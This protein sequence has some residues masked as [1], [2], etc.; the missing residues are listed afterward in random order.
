MGYKEIALIELI[1]IE[2]DNEGHKVL[3]NIDLQL[4]KGKIHAIVGDHDSGKSYICELLSG[5][6][7]P[8]RGAMFIDNEEVSNFTIKKAQ[9]WGIQ[10]IYQDMP[11]I[12]NFSI[13]ENLFTPNFLRKRGYYKKSYIYS[14]SK[15]I[16]NKYHL[17]IDP[18]RL[19]KDLHLTDKIVIN[20][21]RALIRSP[22]LLIL[23]ESLEKL[24]GKDIKRV[25]L[26]L[27]IAVKEG[28]SVLC[29]SH[30]IDDIYNFTDSVSILRRGQIFL[31]DSITNIDRLN[32]IKLCYSQINSDGELSNTSREFYQLIKY[33]EAILQKLPTNLIVTDA[34]NR[35]K[36]INESGKKYFSVENVVLR[37]RGIEELL[38]VDNE[39]FISELFVAFSR[40][41]ETSQYSI[42]FLLSGEIRVVNFKTFPI[43][44]GAFLLGNIII[45]EDISE[46][47]KL[48]EQITLSEKLASVGLL[49]AGVAHEI[50]NPLEIIY[51]HLNYLNMGTLNSEYK[52]VITEIEEELK[53]IKSIV[54]NLISFS[55]NNNASTEEY[56]L[57]DLVRSLINLIVFNG[58]HNKISI[59]F[60]SKSEEILVK[61]SK[62]EMKQ[63]LLNLFKNSF[64]AMPNGGEIIISTD[65]IIK[66][67]IN[68]SM[69]TM[70]DNGHGFEEKDLGDLFLP[71]FSTKKGRENNMGLGLSVIY[72]I[73]KKYRGEIS[74]ENRRG[75]G[76]KFEILL[77]S[78]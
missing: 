44:D 75:G 52:V 51:N 18:G 29:L 45:I 53:D 13:A 70:E 55:D 74:A 69:I 49:A 76:A 64:E 2:L 6:V 7:A 28:L 5:V 50:N 41:E 35:I 34:E 72:G 25:S 24:S 59:N 4:F 48:R 12:E 38:G 68:Y 31:T 78:K 11:L 30:K 19:Y 14:E 62:N 23:D 26:I 65:N 20:I 73:I 47:E 63:V 39:R 9:S 15:K 77:P 21:I 27:K 42:P 67:D 3:R 54:S 66:N 56:N 40:R 43:Y 37:G 10:T 58:N 22:K 33:N 60:K 36:L 1:N 57:N 16:M 71:F 46:Q 8:S 61:S 17:D 32:L